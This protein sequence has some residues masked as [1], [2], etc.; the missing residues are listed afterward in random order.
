MKISVIIPAL[1][2]QQH[3][4]ACVQSAFDACANQVI[5]VDGGSSDKTI[6]LA[7]A[8][9]ADVLSSNAGRAAQQNLGAKHAHGEILLFLH[10]DSRLSKNSI[11]QIRR[12]GTGK[13][14]IC[15]GMRQKIEA[16][17]F[18]YRLLEI[19]N[20]MRITWLGL[21]YGD[22]A[23]FVSRLLFEQLGGFPAGFM[24]DYRLMQSMRKRCWPVL[25]SGPVY[26]NAR[27]WQ[28]QGIIRQTLLNWKILFQYK[29]GTSIQQL[30]KL[31]R[32][33]DL[34]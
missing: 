4:E 14:F 15:G 16:Q 32:R 22:Q 17:G 13:E 9:G 5:V 20:A 1:N 25:L 6:E 28:Q 19:G 23:I 33:H 7:R 2:E 30:E 18:N 34:D 11:E 26:V 10:A 12:V 3:I 31:Y 27:R 29:R 21:P 24:E 8:A